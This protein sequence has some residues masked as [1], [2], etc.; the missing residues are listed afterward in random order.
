MTLLF[1]ITDPVGDNIQLEIFWQ[2]IELT[3]YD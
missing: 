1:M 3:D 2:Q